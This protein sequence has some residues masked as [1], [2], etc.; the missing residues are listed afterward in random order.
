MRKLVF[1]V[2]LNFFSLV[3]FSFSPV[4]PVATVPF[5]MVGSYVV[6]QVRINNSTK[7]SLVL[8]TGVRSTIITELL[9]GD[10]I[11]LNY[12]NVRDLQ[13]LGQGVKLNA[14]LSSSNTL[15]LSRKF[16]LTNKTVYVLQEDVFNLTRQTGTK[17]NGLLGADFF[18]DYIVQIDYTKGRLR[19]YDKDA[20]EVPKGYGV[21]PMTIEKQ[22]MY[23]HLSVLE[24]ILLTRGSPGCHCAPRSLP[25][26]WCTP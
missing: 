17:I 10:S 5:E 9:P 7:L 19:F 26:N 13:G 25:I 2:I 6:V 15:Q 14:Y 12:T 23:I 4:K 16:K 21:M 20:F 22:K 8:D 3:C 1:L 18:Q 11:D 24:T